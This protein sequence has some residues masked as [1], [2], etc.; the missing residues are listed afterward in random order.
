MVIK[1]GFCEEMDKKWPK[2]ALKCYLYG[3]LE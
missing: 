1:W 2:M 3:I